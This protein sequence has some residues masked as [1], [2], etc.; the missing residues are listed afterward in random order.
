[1]RDPGRAAGANA[2]GETMGEGYL[3]IRDYITRNPDA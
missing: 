3:N 2:V 1:M